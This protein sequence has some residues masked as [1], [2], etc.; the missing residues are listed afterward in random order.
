MHSNGFK[1]RSTDDGNNG[2]G[3]VM[4]YMAFAENPLVDSTGKIPA[5]ARLDE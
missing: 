5:T 4:I 1:L 2:N 3:H